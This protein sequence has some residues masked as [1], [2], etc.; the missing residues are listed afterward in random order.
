[1]ASTARDQAAHFARRVGSSIAGAKRPTP[2]QVAAKPY[3]Y[4]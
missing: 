2:A 4:G 1:V 3:R